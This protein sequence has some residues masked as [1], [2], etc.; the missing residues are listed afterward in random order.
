MMNFS[1]LGSILNN[2]Y[3]LFCFALGI[4]AGAEAVRNQP[5]GGQFWGAMWTCTGLAAAGL[6]V[7]LARTLSG[8][9]L[10]AVYLLYELYFVI[11]FP[12]TFALLRGRDD[13]TAAAIFAF[14]A[15]FSA[16]SALSA[17]DASRH[18]VAPLTPGATPA[19]S[20]VIFRLA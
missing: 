7:W 4:W 19:P 6:L 11:V 18:V 5:L 13:R 10:R 9:D 2:A 16:L 1:T 14:I 12:G 15:I 8:E 17:G 3:V 20:A